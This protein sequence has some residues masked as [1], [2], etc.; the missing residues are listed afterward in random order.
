MSETLY[1]FY[2]QWFID[3]KWPRRSTSACLNTVYPFGKLQS[4]HK[5]VQWLFYLKLMSTHVC[6]LVFLARRGVDFHVIFCLH[7]INLSY[8]GHVLYLAPNWNGGKPRPFFTHWESIEKKLLS[9][10][11]RC[12][13][14]NMRVL[15]M[16]IMHC[17]YALSVLRRDVSGQKQVKAPVWVD[18]RCV[19]AL[20]V[21][22]CVKNVC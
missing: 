10:P 14:T 1:M 17:L 7:A 12:G 22:C 21:F 18:S 4:L 19:G 15:K 13:K 3:P 2:L 11:N 20:N 6:L 16:S 8:E 9:Y 5:T